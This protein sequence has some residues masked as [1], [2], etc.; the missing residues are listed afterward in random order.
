MQIRIYGNRH[1]GSKVLNETV[2]VQ[3]DD[4]LEPDIVVAYQAAQAKVEVW[5][6][7]ANAPSPVR[8]TRR[9]SSATASAPVPAKKPK[10]GGHAGTGRGNKIVQVVEATAEINALSS[11]ILRDLNNVF[12]GAQDTEQIFEDAASVIRKHMLISSNH[13]KE[14]VAAVET[15]Q[16]IANGKH[17]R[18]VRTLRRYKAEIVA[19]IEELCDDRISQIQ[20]AESVLKYFDQDGSKE[21][22]SAGG[23]DNKV[24]D[25][26]VAVNAIIVSGLRRFLAAQREKYRGRFPHHERVAMQSV[27]SAS[28]A[29]CDE[30]QA[31]AVARALH[32]NN[33]HASS[34]EL[35]F[36]QYSSGERRPVFEEVEMAPTPYPDNWAEFVTEYWIEK[37]RPS[38]RMSDSVRNPQN[39]EKD[40]RVHFRDDRKED[41][42]VWCLA[43][44]KKEFDST[45]HLSYWKFAQMEPYYVRK[46]GRTTC[47]CRYHLE[48][49]KFVTADASFRKKLSA[50]EG[51]VR[52]EKGSP[53]RLGYPVLKQRGITPIE[54][55]GGSRACVGQASPLEGPLRPVP[56]LIQ[57]GATR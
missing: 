34:G 48:Y 54:P 7:R 52:L 22:H 19:V 32:V 25:K 12:A 53:Q 17:G 39:R 4:D 35:R 43:A 38:E 14:S 1:D 20:L 47:F 33:A 49:R 28:V 16:Q 24:S 57:R 30:G 36:E 15:I 29:S 41:M 9:R 3:L 31:A 40:H 27:I 46:A 2:T 50:C 13:C 10:Y 37:T 26:D 45:F 55:K 42:Y 51:R 11:V 8:R 5:L 23:S 21:V 18:S 44:G 6:A 56:R